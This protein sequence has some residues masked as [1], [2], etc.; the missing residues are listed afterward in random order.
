[1]IVYWYELTWRQVD[2]LVIITN[3][4]EVWA[5]PLPDTL[6]MTWLLI[7]DYWL[8]ITGF[9]ILVY[10]SVQHSFG[11]V[12][13]NWPFGLCVCLPQAGRH[14]HSPQGQFLYTIPCAVAQNILFLAH[15]L[16]ST[17]SL[18]MICPVRLNILAYLGLCNSLTEVG[19][20]V[21]TDLFL[22]RCHPMS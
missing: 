16:L 14:T 9:V 15:F 5:S 21:G 4:Y 17:L 1:M 19:R 6:S 12:C 13:R 18:K 10:N 3:L 11:L 22:S 7:T 20:D 2:P 8:L